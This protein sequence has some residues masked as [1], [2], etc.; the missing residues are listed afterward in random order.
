MLV[1]EKMQS[2]S[3][4]RLENGNLSRVSESGN[5]VSM[6]TGHSEL[7]NSMEDESNHT[8]HDRLLGEDT[9][10]SPSGSGTSTRKRFNSFSLVP[11]FELF[12]AFQ[13]TNIRVK[14]KD[15]NNRI[16]NDFFLKLYYSFVEQNFMGN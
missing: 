8:E 14:R 2:E 4:S 10:Q 6:D 12:L 9:H 7:K 11:D 5:E 3:L 13:Y 16:K 15:I 1:Y